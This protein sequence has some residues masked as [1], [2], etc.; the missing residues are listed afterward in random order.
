MRFLFILT[1]MTPMCFASPISGGSCNGGGTAAEFRLIPTGGCNQG[2][3]FLEETLYFKTSTS[4]LDLNL[5]LIELSNPTA[6]SLLVKITVPVFDPTN[7]FGIA[8]RPIVGE[9][10]LTTK[11][12]G[13]RVIGPVV[14]AQEF[15][16]GSIYG[17][18]VTDGGVA[19]SAL[20]FPVDQP[21]PTPEPATFG[22]AAL[23]LAWVA[24]Q[25]RP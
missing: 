20:F 8:F 3:W 6:D 14:F 1:L 21:A 17:T 4:D 11:A 12:Y 22:L 9:V 15:V 2:I 16:T 18:L 25:R 24:R 19:N 23:A 13:Y 7:G 5:V 10:S